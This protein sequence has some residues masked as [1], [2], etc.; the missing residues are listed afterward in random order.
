MDKSCESCRYLQTFTPRPDE[1]RMGLVIGCKKP[2]YEGYT[3]PL[4]MACDGVFYEQNP[5]TKEPSDDR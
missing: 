2:G 3:S 4:K 5:P 1:L